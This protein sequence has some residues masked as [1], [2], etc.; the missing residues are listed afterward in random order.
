[1][2]ILSDEKKKILLLKIYF[3]KSI[4]QGSLNQK[5]EREVLKEI[6]KFEFNY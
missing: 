5:K 3:Q 1:M 2:D 4:S 6:K